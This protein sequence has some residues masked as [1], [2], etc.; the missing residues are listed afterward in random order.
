MA[1]RVM[2]DLALR[3]SVDAA[4]LKK[5]LQQANTQLSG[6]QKNTTNI[7]GQVMGAFA[8]MG[9][10]IG[11]VAGA[12]KLVKTAII[13]TNAGAD[14]FER[15]ISALK[16]SFDVLNKSLSTGN[17]MGLSDRLKEAAIAGAEYADAMDEIGDR[18]RAYNVFSAETRFHLA[19][20][21]LIFRDKTGKYAVTEK[22]D[23]LNEYT[24]T[25]KNNARELVEIKEQELKAE[26]DKA[27]AISQ[28]SED[29]IESM[30]KFYGRDI[31]I[32]NKVKN[33]SA[34]MKDIYE[35]QFSYKPGKYDV[36]EYIKKTSYD[37]FALEAR[38]YNIIKA[39][40]LTDDQLDVVGNAFSGLADA[41][42]GVIDVDTHLIKYT[43]SVTNEMKKEKKAVDDVADSFEKLPS[44]TKIPSYTPTAPKGDKL[45]GGHTYN[46]LMDSIIGSPESIQAQID[47]LNNM[48]K[49]GVMMMADSIASGIEGLVAGGDFGLDDFFIGILGAFGNFIKQMG[50]A[51]M[52]YGIAMEAFKKAFTNPIAAIVAGLAL[53]ITGSI[54]S[55]LASRAAG[56]KLGK[57][58]SEFAE[59]GLVYGDTLAR[60]GEY[61]NARFDPEIISPLSKLQNIL[62]GSMGGE[63][64]F[65]IDGRYLKGILQKVNVKDNSY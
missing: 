19:Q 65:R 53:I 54:I 57:G 2:T 33:A 35:Q 40:D 31:D 60:V 62:G 13:S 27:N 21:E 48:V 28:L 32:I 12:L 64:V 43:N 58:V 11:G 63:V 4:E 26:L 24:E 51:I 38:W 15:T 44:L 22:M 17:L 10:A 45:V 30:V 5:G 3:L 1:N 39:L 7:G 25:A 42:T 6:L 34:E 36:D 47:D 29:E 55:G 37:S 14:A 16:T 9:L 59:G 61:P 8:K 20:L 23:A 49:N 41:Q 52:S 56:G 50:F 46:S 18:M